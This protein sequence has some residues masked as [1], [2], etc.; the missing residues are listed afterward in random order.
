[1]A[2]VQKE[3]NMQKSTKVMGCLLAIILL[4]SIIYYAV[5]RQQL[6]Y[7]FAENEQIS[8]VVAVTLDKDTTVRQRL[9]ADKDE[10]SRLCIP[11]GRKGESAPISVRLTQADAV[12]YEADVP[13]TVAEGELQDLLANVVSIH[14]GT[15]LILELRSP[16]ATAE[17]ASVLYYGNIVR[18]SRVDV[19]QRIDTQE[20]MLIDGK[21]VDGMLSYRSI[22]RSRQWIG[23]YY[24]LI[25]AMVLL[26]LMGYS[27]Y[28]TRRE[29][30]GRPSLGLNLINAFTRYRFLITQMISRDF[31]T[32][33]KRSV[34]GVMWSF[35]NPLLT[36]SV[37]YVVFSTIFKSSIPNFPVY[38]LIG[39]VCYSFF[40]DAV[41]QSL[42]SIVGNAN[43][44]TKVYVPKY[45]YP[46]TRV[47]SSGINLLFSLV[48]LVLVML[49]SATPFR[50][51]AL[52]IPFPLLCLL[53]FCI[54]M[55]LLLSTSMTFFRDTQFLWQVVSMLWM[56]ATP[57]FYPENILPSPW[58]LLIKANPLYHV[59]RLMRSMLMDGISPDLRTYAVCF[60]ICFIPF[61]IGAWVFKRNQ[62]RFILY[63]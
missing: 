30:Q 61:V 2:R 53:L 17:N 43:L 4:F 23:Q 46:V 15:P 28:L 9:S 35:L 22:Q 25:V 48:P 34:L 39:I 57:I 49:L 41:G 13:I 51:A 55:G 5:S 47:L 12:L 52:M 45:I 27:L 16:S 14:V 38:L 19:E 21:P 56:Y 50:P 1:M 26:A 29:K 36:M 31:K 24:W 20:R 18:L 7:V 63:I 10:L 62:D 42:M 3:T 40:T 60:V 32:K 59:I 11:V 6:E 8:P 37:Q 58:N 44:I 33:Y 54:G